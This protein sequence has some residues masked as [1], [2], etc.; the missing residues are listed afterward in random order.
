MDNEFY[1]NPWSLSSPISYN[2]SLTVV[3]L[4]HDPQGAGVGR[5]HEAVEAALALPE[6]GLASAPAQ[7]AQLGG[8]PP[9]HPGQGRL[10]DVHQLP[11]VAL[12]PLR[13][14]RPGPCLG[15]TGK[16][17]IMLFLAM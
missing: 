6:A 2:M 3:D 9:P 14:L 4:L 11:G 1:L 5:G 12:C 15:R 13:V 16:I 10:H 8:D 7:A 17:A